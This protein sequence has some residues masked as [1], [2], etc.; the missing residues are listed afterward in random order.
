MSDGFYAAQA[1]YDAQEEPEFC[2]VCDTIL[3]WNGV[4]STCRDATYDGPD[5]R[6]PEPCDCPECSR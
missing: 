5:E 3:S 6:E 2:E 1:A 4:C